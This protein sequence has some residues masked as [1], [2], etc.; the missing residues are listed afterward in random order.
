MRK[1]LTLKQ[2]IITLFLTILFVGY[3]GNVSFFVHEHK[4][5]D[6]VV[7]HSHPFKTS[8]HSHSA[9]AI[10]TLSIISHFESLQVVN[11]SGDEVEMHLLA[12]VENCD[13]EQ[14]ETDFIRVSS[15]RAPP[16]L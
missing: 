16:I 7:V 6:I 14:V 2:R 10:N 4:V 13:I 15:L 8:S 3:V 12:V 5:G 1:E 11:L 9:S